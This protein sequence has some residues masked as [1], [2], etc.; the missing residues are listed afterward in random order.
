VWPTLPTVKL[1]PPWKILSASQEHLPPFTETEGSLPC[2]KEPA[3]GP[4]PEP[5]VSS[6]SE[7]LH[8][9]LVL[10]VRSCYPLSKPPSW[11][12]TICPL[13]ATAYSIQSQPLSISGGRL[14]HPRHAV[15]TRTLIA[16]YSVCTTPTV[17]TEQLIYCIQKPRAVMSVCSPA[18][19]TPDS[20]QRPC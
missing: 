3:S 20:N 5:D 11:K 13:S 8:R 19:I 2:S 16:W 14:F 1:L 17:H 4:Y 9:M 18:W 12:T 10:R 15:M 7:T 6:K